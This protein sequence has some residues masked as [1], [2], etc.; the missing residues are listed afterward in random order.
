MIT[1]PIDNIR[2]GEPMVINDTN[3]DWELTAADLCVVCMLIETGTR[4][5][6]EGRITNNYEILLHCICDRPEYLDFGDVNHRLFWDLNSLMT[7]YKLL[8]TIL[9][10]Y[11][12]AIVSDIR[13]P[14]ITKFEL[15]PEVARHWNMRSG[16]LVINPFEVQKSARKV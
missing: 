10:Q 7:E 1:Y 5:R 15:T 3:I 16:G 2:F 11:A 14:I 6:Y 13:H 8:G 12:A 4:V 9:H